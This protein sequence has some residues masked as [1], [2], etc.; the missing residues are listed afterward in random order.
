MSSQSSNAVHRASINE[1]DPLSA[2]HIYYG[3]SHKKTNKTRTYSNVVD[4]AGRREAALAAGLKQ[5]GRR[6]SHDEHSSQ[7]R[8][9]L[10]PVDE[11]LKTLL[12][13]E[14]TDQNYQITIEDSGPKVLSVGTAGSNGLNRFD[15]RGTYMLSN[16]LQELTLAQDYGRKSIVL[17]EARLNENPVNRLSRLI[18]DSFWNNLTR[19]TDASNIAR[20]ARDPK[21][22]TDNPHPRVYIPRGAPEQYEYYQKHA[23]AHP[24]EKLE[25]IYLS[26]DCNNEEYV[27]D[28]NDAPG[29]LAL[30][31]EEY[32][33]PETGENDW[34]GRPFVVPGGRFNELY[35]WDSYMESMGLLVNDRVDLVQSMVQ[36]FCFCIKHYGK[37]LNGNRTY[38]LCRSQPPFLTD[39]SLRVYERIKHEPGA[40]E[41]LR[42][43]IMAAIKEYY[44]VWMAEP[45]YDKE[46]GLSKYRPGGIGVP[47]ETEASH[48][49]HV[50]EPYCKKNNMGFAEFVKAYNERKVS[51][52]ELDAYFTHDRAVRESGH[53]TSYRLEG[54]AADLA[55]VDL[56][57]LLYKYE[58]DIARTIR[59]YFGD[60]L[61]IP[62]EFCVAGQEPNHIETS[63]IWDRRAKR[64]KALMEKLMWN[65]E[66]GMFFDYNTVKKEQTG[67]ESA[68]TFWP[69]WAGVATPRQA[70]AL[71]SKALPKF[72][73]IGGLVSGT[74][75]SRGKVG[76]ER[77]NRQ[78]DYPFGW[79]PQQI[80]AWVGLQRYGYENEAQRLA[81]KWCYMVTKA[82]V[83][84][85]GVVVE[86]YDVTRPIDPHR[87][88]AEYGNQGS[89]FKGVP[90][91]GF[92]WV[93]A[94]YVYGLQLLNAHMRRALGALTTYDTFV[95]ATEALG[96]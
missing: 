71:V 25:V 81:Y 32:F 88:E 78:W 68:T 41:F 28:L 96:F 8:K 63:A 39:M 16:L 82:F 84:F 58:T 40:Q 94:S 70:V 29:L 85:N 89:D 73:E 18:K 13:R 38:Y 91:E 66:E 55:T 64:R 12:A 20:I 59:G 80:L 90:R 54:V 22:W 56:N 57:S 72:E 43:S 10:I 49:V 46:S 6:S 86:K 92:G 14:D 53:D 79:A 36:N 52:P 37:I 65:E 7:P 23:E 15:V 74:E 27:R 34:R 69:M 5:P 93:N 76:L 33:N 60:R 2:A 24:E 30:D 35:G 31:M 50:L 4:S 95:K 3:D 44:S 42:T 21:D 11:T 47:P 77:P 19:R 51:E 1:R 62:A 67:Y 87:V 61:T 75:K 17:D 48:F 83:D 26:Y 9:F 45:R